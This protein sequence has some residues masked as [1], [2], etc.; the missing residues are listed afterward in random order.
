MFSGLRVKKSEVSFATRV[1]D[2]R[3]QKGIVQGANKCKQML[4]AKWWRYTTYGHRSRG[5]KA[6]RLG[7]AGQKGQR[8]IHRLCWTWRAKATL[9]LSDRASSELAAQFRGIERGKSC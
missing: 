4:R 1:C 2:L 3:V 7:L 8:R 5:G 9:S 6:R